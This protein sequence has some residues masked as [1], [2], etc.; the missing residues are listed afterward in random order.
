MTTCVIGSMREY[1]RIQDIAGQLKQKGRKVLTPLDV[2]G[3]RFA[4]HVQAKNEFMR[5]MYDQIKQCDAVLVVND[6]TRNGI[7]GY[8]GPNTFLQLGMAMALGKTLYALNKWDDKLP[9]DEELQAMGI[10]VI[11]IQN[12]F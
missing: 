10:N 12:R 6:R 9:Y 2:S 5:G 1:D 8:I 4:D 11:D 7:Q 3:D